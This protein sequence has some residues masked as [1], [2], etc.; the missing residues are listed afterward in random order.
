M[1]AAIVKPPGRDACSAENR[2]QTASSSG[3]STWHDTT[4]YRSR[5][6]APIEAD[7]R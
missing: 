7:P 1:S 4:A 2:R 5:D 6:V 3:R